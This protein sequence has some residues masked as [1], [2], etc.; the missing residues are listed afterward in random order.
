MYKVKNI[1]KTTQVVYDKG[2][3]R[4]TIEPGETKLMEVPPKES[5]IFHVEKAEQEEEPKKSKGGK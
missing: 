3:K 2:G 1:D 4:V 5:Y